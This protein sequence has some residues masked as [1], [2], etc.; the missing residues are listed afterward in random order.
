MIR[1]V[2]H[3]VGEDDLFKKLA[4]NQG[5]R[6]RSIVSSFFLSPFLMKGAKFAFSS[7]MGLSLD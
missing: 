2:V 4:C 1:Q 3:N 5:D 6:D 7:H